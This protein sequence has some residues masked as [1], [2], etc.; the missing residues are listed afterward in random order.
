MSSG[1][2][3]R[4]R[5][6]LE[7]MGEGYRTR[8]EY[9]ESLAEMDGPGTHRAAIERNGLL[10]RAIERALSEEAPPQSRPSANPYGRDAKHVALQMEVCGIRCIEDAERLRERVEAGAF[11]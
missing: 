6:V 5:K 8:A 4:E 3:A 2:S 9:H 7:K 1:F 10:A 11:D